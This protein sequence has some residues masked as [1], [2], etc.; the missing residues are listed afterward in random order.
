MQLGGGSAPSAGPRPAAPVAHL[1]GRVERALALHP[2]GAWRVALTVGPAM[3]AAAGDR[4]PADDDAGQ[5]DNRSDDHEHCA[6]ASVA[7]GCSP[8]WRSSSR[9][10]RFAAPAAPPRRGCGREAFDTAR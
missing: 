1:P 10:N 7:G 9:A 5:H 3:D 2:A 4:V 8:Y 6:V